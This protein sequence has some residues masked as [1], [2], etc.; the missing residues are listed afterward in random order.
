[1]TI[2]KMIKNL[3]SELLRRPVHW[4]ILLSF[5][6][7]LPA[8][9]FSRGYGMHDDHFGPIEQPWS[10]I[11]NPDIWH[12]RTTPHAHSIFYPLLH[13]FLFKI[14]YSLG[15]NDPQHVMLIVRFL[16]SIYSILTVVFLFKILELFFERKIAF[17]V[18]VLFPL[19]WFMP[20]L[21]VRNLIEMV[22]I[23][24]MAIGYYFLLRNKK[25]VKDLVLASLFFALAFAFRYQTFIITGTIFLVLLF[26]KEFW[27]GFVF[28][29]AFMFFALIIQGSVDIFA[30][31]YPFASFIEYVSY[32]LSHS[33]DYT[34]GP[35][36]R[37]LLLFLG[38]FTFPLSIYI[39]YYFVK[40][41]GKHI[42][43]VLPVIVFFVFHSVFPNK[44]ERFIL[45]IVPF[46]FAFGLANFLTY[47]QNKVIFKTK[48][49]F[50]NF[51][52]V[53]F[54]IINLP[55]FFIFSLN[56]GKKTRCES[57]YFLSKQTD[58]K[59]IF[60]ITGKIGSFKPPEFYLNKY[61]TPIFPIPS[62]DSLGKF[63]SLPNIPNYA[64]IYGDEELDSLKMSVER[65]L[66]RKLIHIKTVEPSLADWILYKLN[67]KYNKNQIANIYKIE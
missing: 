31:G 16:H 34:S 17:R 50:Y 5:L 6:L 48:K 9:F 45:P 67:P 40:D 36:Y 58:V 26:K 8:V 56:Y 59:G 32:N 18:S 20:F 12:S 54:W 55:L 2:V 51:I 63:T 11:N 39:I 57:L 4:L 47:Y 65:I 7:N 23:P 41:V 44:Q 30:W 15:I 29:L 43:I 19:L 13:F 22:C 25:I 27:Y 53:M 42:F 10:I 62:V 24:P 61:G 46:V 1:M 21:S 60:Q 52:W 66:K 37:Y 33:E 14:L 35:F 38:V 64:I 3:E 28:G 49:G